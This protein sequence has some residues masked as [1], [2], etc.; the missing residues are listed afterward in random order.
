MKI[1][2]CVAFSLKLNGIVFI[3]QFTE[4]QILDS[5][6]KKVHISCIVLIGTFPKRL[7]SNFEHVI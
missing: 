2:S 7:V 4:I 6:I 3:Y 5:V 1:K